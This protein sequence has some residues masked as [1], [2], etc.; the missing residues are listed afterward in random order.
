MGLEPTRREIALGAVASPLL[1]GWGQAPAPALTAELI[2]YTSGSKSIR[3]AVYR[4]LGNARGAG[5]VFLHGS[6][7]IGAIQLR[8]ARSFAENGYLTLIPTYTDAAADDIVRGRSV[9]NAWRDSACDAIEWLVSQGIDAG[10]TALTGYSLGSFIAVDG[11]LGDSRAGA[12][13]AVAGGWDVY[14]PRPPLRKIPVL[15]IRAE[16]D[17]RVRPQGTRQWAEFLI[18]RDVPVRSQVIRGAGHLMTRTQWDL[19]SART[20]RFFDSTIGRAA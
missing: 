12:A 3:A 2:R 7:S 18:D 20:L 6:G 16:R 15:L 19:T 10:R 8:Y 5:A 4:P 17:R 14:P 1:G 9:M 11:A 13:V